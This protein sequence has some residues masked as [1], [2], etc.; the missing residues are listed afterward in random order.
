[1]RGAGV[2]IPT[3]PAFRSAPAGSGPVRGGRV[4]T[5]GTFRLC[6]GGRTPRLAA[7]T[8]LAG[9]AVTWGA[10][11]VGR[12]SFTSTWEMRAAAIGPRPK[13]F[14]LTTTTAF[15]TLAFR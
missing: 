13:R 15:R 2:G 6:S 3:A 7:G 14:S 8:K 10:A 5:T 4:A 11:W 12:R 9:V 1:M